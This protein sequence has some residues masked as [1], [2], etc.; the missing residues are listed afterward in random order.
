MVGSIP[1]LRPRRPPGFAAPQDRSPS[2]ATTY[3]GFPAAAGPPPTAAN[4]STRPPGSG[5]PLPGKQP[6]RGKS[7]PATPHH[8]PLGTFYPPIRIPTQLLADHAPPASSPQAQQPPDV[9]HPNPPPPTP[10]QHLACRMPL[11]RAGSS[12][13]GT[14]FPVA[15]QSARSRSPRARSGRPRPVRARNDVQSGSSCSTGCAVPPP[16]DRQRTAAHRARFFGCSC[17]SFPRSRPRFSVFRVFRTTE[18][19]P[20]AGRTVGAEG[21]RM[22]GGRDGQDSRS[23]R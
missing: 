4:A 21:S 13:R 20:R 3:S 22:R 18:P 5:S 10:P 8:R 1:T 7:H 11:P 23:G 15:A 17:R 12:N 19:V 6:R 14:R 9:W 2:L 16:P